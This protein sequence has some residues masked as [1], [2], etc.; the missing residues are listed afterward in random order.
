[1]DI[2]E[3]LEARLRD[4]EAV[5][6]AAADFGADWRFSEDIYPSDDSRH[7]GAIIAGSYG[8]GIPD[9]YGNHVVRHDPARTLRDVEA[10]R[11]LIA[12]ALSRQADRDLEYG[13]DEPCPADR[14][15]ELRILASRWSEHPDF[16]P[17]WSLP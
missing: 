17:S 12:L 5:A 10:D 4:D 9:Q 11:R 15:T 7:P 3:F 8:C 6:R 16:D 2:R 14:I 1:M 13:R